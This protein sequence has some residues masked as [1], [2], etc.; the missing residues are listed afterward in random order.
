MQNKKKI[1]AEKTINYYKGNLKNKTIA[2]WGLSF[3][4]RTDDMREAPSITIIDELKKAGAK[5]RVH[6][7]V[8]M[9]NA[10]EIIGE[11]NVEYFKDKYK[12]LKNTD[13][14]LLVT[15][16]MEYRTPDLMLM[17]ELMNK[18]LIID[19][20]NQFTTEDMEQYGFEYSAIGYGMKIAK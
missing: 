4:P 10:K 13:A 18:K 9:D 15:E 12:C 16:W 11:E 20:R 7:P 19:G 6:D 2:V 8:A 5:I 1:L 3:K 17:S 14:L